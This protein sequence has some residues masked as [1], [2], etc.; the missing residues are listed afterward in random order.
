MEGR[1]PHLRVEAQVQCH[2]T[3][4]MM[5]ALRNAASAPG[6]ITQE[7]RQVQKIARRSRRRPPRPLLLLLLL[8]LL[9]R[10]PPPHPA[11]PRHSPAPAS[12][13]ASSSCWLPC[14]GRWLC[15]C[16]G[17]PSQIP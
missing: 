14:W 4:R 11:K 6:P 10:C 17:G 2:G 16:C 5:A 7:V 3:L 8:Q 1:G 9:R 13:S 12:A 15:G